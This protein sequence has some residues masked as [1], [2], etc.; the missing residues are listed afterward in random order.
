MEFSRKIQKIFQNIS[1][2]WEEEGDE[3]EWGKQRGSYMVKNHHI[4]ARKCHNET[5]H[6]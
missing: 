5:I 6:T 3:Q 1:S 4:D 2:N